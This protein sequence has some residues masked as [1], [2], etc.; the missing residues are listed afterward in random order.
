MTFE[1]VFNSDECPARET[2][3][4]FYEGRLSEVALVL[5]SRHLE[6]CLSSQK[7]MAARL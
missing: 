4:D 7:F 3:F 2:L 6:D 5:V 1:K